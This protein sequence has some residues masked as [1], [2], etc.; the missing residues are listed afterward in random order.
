MLHASSH[1]VVGFIQPTGGGRVLVELTKM[2][3]RYDAVMGVIRDDF[4]VTEIAEKYGVSRQTVHSWLRRYEQGGIEAL[5]DQSHRPQSCP[6]QMDGTVEA[7][8]L[9]L[10]RLYPFW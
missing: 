7:R 5:R 4:N 9:E 6:H 10:R 3:Q 8:I 2:E 1:L